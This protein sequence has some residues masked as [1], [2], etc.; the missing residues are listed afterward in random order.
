MEHEMEARSR[1]S[2]PGVRSSPPATSLVR[3]Q[4]DRCRD[5]LETQPRLPIHHHFLKGTKVNPSEYTPKTSIARIFRHLNLQ[6]S[7]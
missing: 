3:E 5:A 4:R 7:R 2:A 1:A 6:I